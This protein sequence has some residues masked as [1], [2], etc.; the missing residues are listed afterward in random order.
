M[1]CTLKKQTL[2]EKICKFETWIGAT[3]LPHWKHFSAV[4]WNYFDV[5]VAADDVVAVVV[6]DVVES[7]FFAL[8]IR[9]VD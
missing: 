4:V 7:V 2:N 6:V 3:G 1:T 8:A 5:A 9:C